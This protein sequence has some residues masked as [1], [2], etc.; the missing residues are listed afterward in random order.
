MKIAHVIAG[1]HVLDALI[2]VQ[3]I[4]ANLRAEA[5]LG[6]FLVAGGLLGF[7]LFFLDPRQPGP[8]HL[9]RRGPVFVL[10]ALV[11]ALHDDARGHVRQPD[12][13]GRFVDVLAAGAA[14]AEDVFADVLV[15]QLDFDGVADFG[16]HVDRGE[17]GLPLAVGVEGTDAHQ[18]V[19]AGF[20]LQV[21]VGHRTAKGQGRALNAGD[22]VVLAVENLHLVAALLGPVDVHAQ[23]HFGPIVGVGAAVAGING[24]DGPLG[25]EGAVEQPLELQF[26]EE[27]FEAFDFAGHLAGER[28]IFAGHVHQHAQIVGRGNG[29]VER[30]ENRAQRFQFGNRGA[31]FFLII[32]EVRSGHF[33]F[34]GGR[35]PPF[36]GM[37]KESPAVG[38]SAAGWPRPDRSILCP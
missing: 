24:K 3:E 21:A 31:G 2:G 35:L 13:A 15:A 5:G 34:N 7:A 10:R 22:D 25:V 11:L 17:A 8:Q 26:A 37:V 32:P 6:L 30:L 33:L 9:E 1:P 16:R 38:R 4:I 27:L 20:A 29:F 19:H 12:G 14:G 28:A 23:Q 36:A 18:A